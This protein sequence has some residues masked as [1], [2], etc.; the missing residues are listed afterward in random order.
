MPIVTLT[1]DF[2]TRDGFVGALK[3]VVWSI[4]PE[5]QIADITHEIAP[6]NIREGA[7]AL[8]RAYPF[9]PGGTVHVAV[10]DPGVGTTRRPIAARLGEHVFVGPDN[11][12]FTPIYEDASRLGRGVEI[13]HLTNPRY[14]L[15]KVSRTF[16]GRDI[17]SPVAAHLARGVPF[18][19][20]GP[21]VTDP[22]RIPIFR[23]ERT[24]G[25]WKAHISVVDIF[26]NLT[27]DLAA[28]EVLGRGQPLFR[29]HGR[30]VRGLADSY[31]QR[32]PGDLIAL[33]DSEN[34]IEIAVVNGSA[35]QLLGAQ[36]GD[37]VDVIVP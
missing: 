33:V 3:G 35:A 1:T 18:A 11:G 15:P 14:F 21:P 31:G 6:Q 34:N 2:G 36:V 19:D 37:P 23:A 16:H 8:W 30:E 17:F 28:A 7:M 5:A 26:G 27:T 32:K 29:L 20:L 9:F 4:C 22:V 13:V 25:G 12:L 24:A 10:V